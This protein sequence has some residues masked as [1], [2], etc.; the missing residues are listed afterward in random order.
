MSNEVTLEIR[1]EIVDRIFDKWRRGRGPV[2]S[3]DWYDYCAEIGLKK[4]PVGG[5]MVDH[6]AELT[7]IM[8]R[9]NG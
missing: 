5:W 6:E 1:Q 7:M 3:R 4:S 8:L 2:N 9:L